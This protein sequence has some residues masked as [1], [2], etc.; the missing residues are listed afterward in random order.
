MGK[1]RRHTSDW[2]ARW[3]CTAFLKRRELHGGVL[4]VQRS[5]E[6]ERRVAS[7]QIS[8]VDNEDTT[9]VATIRR[10]LHGTQS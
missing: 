10:A 9:R 6:R 1:T 3:N 7:L 2:S 8:P 5:E 4:V